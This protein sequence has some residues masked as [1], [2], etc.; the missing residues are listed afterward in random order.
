MSSLV[1]TNISPATL[2]DLEAIQRLLGQLG[3][4]LDLPVLREQCKLYSSSPSLGL[5]LARRQT[6]TVGLIA[7]SL[8]PLFVKKAW[9]VHVEALVVD[10]AYRHQGIG[11]ALLEYIENMTAPYGPR[12]I[13]LTSGQHRAAT[14]AHAFYR[15]LGYHND[16][17]NEKVYLR[18]ELGK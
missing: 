13:D 14:G 17:V 18:K 4:T 12:I 16:G 1:P 15:S 9:R 5:W 7:F 10:A 2:G 3:Y 8:A 11:R 6:A